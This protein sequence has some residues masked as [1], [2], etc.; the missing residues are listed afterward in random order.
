M[1]GSEV[2]HD[3]NSSLL[4]DGMIDGFSGVSFD[5]DG[6]QPNESDDRWN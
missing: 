1:F 2:L 3:G 4:E 6:C 5:L